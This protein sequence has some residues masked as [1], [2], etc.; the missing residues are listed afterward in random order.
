MRPR[1][2]RLDRGS[3]S[4]EWAIAAPVAFFLLMMV[5]QVAVWAHATHTAQSA[6]GTA[7]TAA[8]VETGS[9]AT[10]GDFA[11]EAIADYGGGSLVDPAASVSRSTEA[12]TVT[13][14]GTAQSLIPGLELPVTVSVTGPVEAFRPDTEG[15]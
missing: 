14:T 8:R 9:A 10:G 1:Q 6:A 12:V 7:L 11:A 15:D 3:V 4:V 13:V 2:H 5:V